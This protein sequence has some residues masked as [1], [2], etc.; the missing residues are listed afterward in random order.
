[1]PRELPAHPNLEYLKREA[2]ELLAEKRPERPEWRLADAQHTLAH[3][4]GFE[5][6]PKL[7]AHVDALTPPV[8]PFVGTW[9]ADVA[10]SR[11]HAANLF[12][13]A[14]LTFSV[15]GDAVTIAH[16]AVD[17]MGRPDSGV[18]SIQAD[19][20]ERVHDFGRQV[21]VRWAG[22]RLLDVR[23]RHAGLDA[24]LATYEI[25]PDGQTM[26]VSTV[27]QRLLFRRRH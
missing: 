12:Q 24:R 3:E 26:V 11:R 4:Y 10:Q 17:D 20:V 21:T 23:T 27:D 6:W 14:T 19:G 2:K 15:T 5:S 13:R 7:K 25:S 1:M 9:E 16:D 22:S 18:I 8:S